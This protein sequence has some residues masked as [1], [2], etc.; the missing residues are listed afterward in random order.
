V[1]IETWRKSP[2]PFLVTNGC[3]DLNN[4]N[5]NIQRHEDFYENMEIFIERCRN[6]TVFY[7]KKLKRV[8]I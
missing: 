8:D 7:F 2:D 5:E 1:I 4:F 3:E 6:T